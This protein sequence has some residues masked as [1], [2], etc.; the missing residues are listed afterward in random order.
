MSKNI[1]FN[2]IEKKILELALLDDDRLQQLYSNELFGCNY[3]PDHVQ[4]L[5]PKLEKIF[6]EDGMTI[7]PTEYHMVERTDG[8]NTRFGI[9]RINENYKA[10]IQNL[11]KEYN[12]ES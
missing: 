6:D 10:K 1:K 3:L 7:F 5:R 8:K 12:S 9:Y 11:L 2:E 4:H